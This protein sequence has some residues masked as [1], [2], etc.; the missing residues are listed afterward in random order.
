MVIDLNPQQRAAV[1][2]INAPLLVLSGA[3]SGKTR[4][5]TEKIAHL[6]TRHDV[7]A[8]RILALTFTNKAAK[9]M[10]TR[11]RDLLPAQSAR[12]LKIGTFHQFGLNIIRK[13]LKSLPLRA[14][15]SILDE[16][17]SRHLITDILGA[18]DQDENIDTQ[19]IKN[20]ISHFKNNRRSPQEALSHALNDLDQRAALAYAKYQQRLKLYNA[21]DFDDLIYLPLWLLQNNYSIR[22]KWQSRIEYVLVDEYQDTNACQYE[23]FRQLVEGKEKFTVVGDDDQSIYGWRG[24]CPDNLHILHDDYPTLKIVKLEQNYRSF[25]RILKVANAVIGNNP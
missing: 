3:G 8:R 17:D 23:L 15:F 24:A 7:P 9:E 20:K 19:I 10:L 21:V 14:G 6:I 25:Q 1:T 4:V 2:E 16:A 22:Q 13:E 5:I 11:A 18:E 12:G